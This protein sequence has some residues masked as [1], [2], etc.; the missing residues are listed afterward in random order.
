MRLIERGC[1]ESAMLISDV[2][3][4]RIGGYVIAMCLCLTHSENPRPGR[5]NRAVEGSLPE[6]DQQTLP[7]P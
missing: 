7:K 2:P 4:Y 3:P 1:L 5:V 6:A